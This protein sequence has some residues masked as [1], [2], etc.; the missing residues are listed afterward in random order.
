MN[1]LSSV[2]VGINLWCPNFKS[3]L[4]YYTAFQT[5]YKF[6]P[7]ENC[8]RKAGLKLNDLYDTTC[9]IQLV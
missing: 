4:I 2:V 9:M 1:T 7:F 6:F 3:E 8:E 5:R